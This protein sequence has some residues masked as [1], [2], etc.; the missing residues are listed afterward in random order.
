MADE[1]WEHARIR[2]RA[3]QEKHNK[4]CAAVEKL[5]GK[6]EPTPQE[7]GAAVGQVIAGYS[8]AN[9]ALWGLELAKAAKAGR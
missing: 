1:R 9:G 7:L 3:A 4:L 8:K 5:V 2:A 6:F